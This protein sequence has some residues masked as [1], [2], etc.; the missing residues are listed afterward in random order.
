ML[1]IPPG[2]A[3]G[4]RV[5]SETAQVL[6][7]ATDLYHPECERTLAWNDPDVNID[8]QL[9]GEA[10]ISGKD[11]LGLPLREAETFE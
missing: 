8:W 3:H 4:F 9:D 1:W 6:Y 7:K 5:V 11:G 10:V 2:F